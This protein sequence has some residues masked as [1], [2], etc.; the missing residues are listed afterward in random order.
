MKLYLQLLFL[1]IT[2]MIYDSGELFAQS[3]TTEYQTDEIMV[4]GTR[5]EQKI[6]DIPYSV[7]RVDKTQWKFARKQGINDVLPT[8]PGLFLQSRYGNHDVRVSI[9]GFGSRSNSGIRGVRIML[10]G[11]PESEP[12][13]QTRIEVLDFTSI[14]KIELV[15]GNSSSLYTN[16]PGGV[17]NFFTDKYFLSSFVLA[18]NEFGSYGLR[19]NGFK[20]GVNSHNSRFMI[21]TSY[22]NYN[23]Y[24]IH[25]Q[26]YQ[27]RLNA[28][29]EADITSKSK[30]LVNGYYVNGIIKLPGSLSLTDYNNTDTSANARDLSR[31]AKRI[32][33]K[34]R[35]GVTYSVDFGTDK[36]LN[37]F[38][39]TGYGT[40]KDL[41]RTA[42][43]YRV[44]NRYG[45]GSSFRYVNKLTFGTKKQLRTNEFSV[46]GDFFFQTGPI[47][48][49]DNLAGQKG[50]LLQNLNTETISN[51]GFYVLDQ[52]T[53]IPNRLSLL[54]TGRYDRVRFTST[55]EQGS[56]QDTSRMFNEFT[57]KFALSLKL[58]PNIAFYTSF[59]IGF[60]SPAF[61]EMDNYAFSSDGG[62]HLLNPDLKPQKSLNFEAGIKGSVSGLRKKYFTNTSFELTVYKNKIDEVIVP[63]TVDGDVF[64][65]NAASTKRMGLEAGIS[66]EVIE[67]L[68]LKAAYTVQDFKYG[69][70]L[71]GVIDAQGNLTDMDFS[72][73]IEPSN[74]KSFFSSELS[75]QYTFRKN[76][77]F[78]VKGSFQ[79]V[80]EMFVDDANSDSLKTKGY[81]VLNSQIG[82]DLTFKNFKILA[83]AGMNNLLDEKYVA[84]IT[85]NSDRLEFYESGARRNF[86]SG[87]T[88]AYMF[89]K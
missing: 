67:G 69:S 71:A 83:Y 19:K 79:Q 28:L 1:F 4:T 74:P 38:E 52:I 9:R 36:M 55:N 64:F 88:L 61:N 78:F 49:F 5:V 24:R 62:L 17:I 20:V 76:Y 44:F 53:V 31:D 48:E 46:G 11:I 27:N 30:L 42:R 12:D 85:I 13:G 59:G 86:F 58:T 65:R 16:S 89:N 26:E 35:I 37:K 70:Y 80:G 8:V 72:G 15:K 50:D 32:S 22:E 43:T 77:T 7:E 2:F 6:I 41:E 25:S 47:S 18:D 3:D 51:V 39:V 23:G 87:L 63:F 73:H 29:Y 66:T 82:I 21:T 14:G 68:K 54:V 34:G 57:P 10:D 60:D 84:F 45:I 40:I 56:F 75:Y 33:K 81:K